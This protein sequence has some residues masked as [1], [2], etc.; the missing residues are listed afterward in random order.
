[1]QGISVAGAHHAGGT[2]SFTECPTNKCLGDEKPGHLWTLRQVCFEGAECRKR[3]LRFG[4][5][6]EIGKFGFLGVAVATL[7][8]GPR[9]R[10]RPQHRGLQR[11]FPRALKDA[12]AISSASATPLADQNVLEGGGS[13]SSKDTITGQQD[14]T[15]QATLNYT[16]KRQP[17]VPVQQ[18]LRVKVQVDGQ[19]E[20]VALGERSRSGSMAW[21]Y[22]K[23]PLVTELLSIHPDLSPAAASAAAAAFLQQAALVAT[24]LLRRSPSERRRLMDGLADLRPPDP[25]EAA[26]R[27]QRRRVHQALQNLSRFLLD[28][29]RQRLV[30]LTSAA[31]GGRNALKRFVEEAIG[32]KRQ[33]RIVSR[34][35]GTL[36]E[37]VLRSS[38][39]GRPDEK[40]AAAYRD[41]ALE[42]MRKRWNVAFH[43]WCAE[44][45]TYYYLLDAEVRQRWVF[46]S[47]GDRS[48]VTVLSHMRKAG[49][50]GKTASW[51]ALAA[52][53]P[54]Q[55]A[56]L[57]MVDLGSCGNF[58]G[59]ECRHHF[60]VTALDLA[61]ADTSVFE[62]DCLDLTVG[63]AG[64]M[65]V[66]SKEGRIGGGAGL[67]RQLPAQGFRVAV[68]G[69]LLSYIADPSLRAQIVAKVR[70][71]LPSD[72]SGLLIIADTVASVGR[73][74]CVAR[75]PGTWI[76][77]VEA[78]GFRLLTDPQM[79]FASLRDS[80]TGAVNRAACF[81]F[82]TV[83]TVPTSGP[84]LRSESGATPAC[85]TAER[86]PPIHYL[87]DERDCRQAAVQV[88]DRQRSRSG[89][90]R[91][92]GGRQPHQSSQNGP[93]RREN[94]SNN[95]GF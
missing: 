9:R 91:R 82:A 67:L 50:E 78:A 29:P 16:S 17:P 95:L 26:G 42:N 59:N 54:A 87:G 36:H 23:P 81:S 63:P 73:H 52:V 40:L 2:S 34:S 61:P 38:R 58:F 90:R 28:W 44:A 33:L 6:K 66:V 12:S 55:G 4:R 31:A 5:P 53:L 94:M 22:L 79:H 84:S 49:Q 18:Q 68:L 21:D 57:K 7:C 45:I 24:D 74:T 39:D 1:M 85:L 35:F 93:Q 32:T 27:V 60:D 37:Q 76:A 70:Q 88:P 10:G 77:A 46:G 92:A 51:E 65:P 20:K 41:A 14:Q 56:R 13:A 89:G 69:L 47:R 62:C 80:K 71:L 11:C 48:R 72:S 83:P 15:T 19:P 30:S 8:W 25:K 64:S 86:S 3:S 43:E 75:P